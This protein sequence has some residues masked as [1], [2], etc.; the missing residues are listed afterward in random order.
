[1]AAKLLLLCS[2]AIAGL[3]ILQAG[4]SAIHRLVRPNPS[5][6]FADS[7]H[8]IAPIPDEVGTNIVGRAPGPA[9]RSCMS[10]S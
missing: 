1:M 10:A 8:E 2:L 6:Q 5:L 7:I 9:K 3:G 4:T